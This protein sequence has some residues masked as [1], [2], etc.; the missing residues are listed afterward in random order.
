MSAR[1]TPP[2]QAASEASH[3]A[4][5][6]EYWAC[7]LLR[8]CPGLGARTWKKILSSFKSAREAFDERASWRRMGLVDSRQE[9][10]ILSGAAE[11]AA[12]REYEL[13]CDKGLS[14]LT[15]HDPRYPARLR[16][17]P[18]PPVILYFLGDL[19]YL[20]GPG[21]ALVGSRTC[22]RYGFDSALSIARGLS[23]AGVTVISGL[24]YGIDR[25]AHLGGLSGPGGSVAVLGTGLDLVYPDA[26][27][28]VWKRLAESGLILTEFPP[29]TR[30][31][32]SN[33]PVRNRIISGLSLGVAV[34]E[35]AAR[36]GSLI[37]AR[38]AM[39]QGREVF[40]MPGPATL[41]TFRGCHDL[42]SQGAFLITS[43]ED[44]LR[45]LAPQL[46]A[47]LRDRAG[48]GDG[49]ADSG[50]SSRRVRID[51]PGAADAAMRAKSAL[52]PLLREPPA[53]E[54]PHAASCD[55]RKK[56]AQG[57]PGNA[58]VSSDAS[59]VT[60]GAGCADAEVLA[61][62]GETERAT[63]SWLAGRESAH[64]DAIG[65]ELGLSSG[66]ASRVLLILEL[67]GLVRKRP[68][69]YY[70]ATL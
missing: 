20:D 1:P 61:T 7:L 32:A 37:T 4:L 64:I 68:G 36:S 52:P 58:P 38:L 57:R 13:V 23:A 62:L 48:R 16:E 15:F 9:R 69:M 31:C 18:D 60:E 8:R 59:Q 63:L 28:D 14:V 33:F 30:P 26:N 53:G 11:E 2:A 17:L 42:I 34:V 19:S 46:E 54:R 10:A 56:G 22:S 27:L 50:E 66:E 43:A 39:E 51:P 21:C 45:E 67:G 6:E 47:A 12:R 3:T 40:A 5:A 24:A 65:R 49:P 70:S 44:V 35:A 41:P 29:G 25:Q 55:K